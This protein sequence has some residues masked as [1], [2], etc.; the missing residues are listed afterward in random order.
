MNRYRCALIRAAVVL[1]L[2]CAWCQT[3]LAQQPELQVDPILLKQVSTV[4]EIVARPDNKLWPGWNA[5][6]TP[7]LIYL[8][9]QQELLLNHPNPPAG[10]VKYTGRFSAE[11]QEVFLRDGETLIEWDAQNTSRDVYGTETLVLADTLSNRKQWLRGWAADPRENETKLQDTDYASLRADAYEQIATIAHEAFHVF[12]MRELQHKVA[13]ERMIRAYPCLSVENNVGFA[14]EAEA[15]L[16][17]LRA[18]NDTELRSAAV[19]WLAIRQDR[20]Q[21]L[22]ADAI[23]YE[24]ANE[25][26][27][28]LAKYIEVVCLENL[29]GTRADESLW[30]SQGFAGFDDT[31]WFREKRLEGLRGNLRGEV[32]VNNDPYGSSPVRG[33]LYFSGMGIGLLLDRI[34][35][36]WKSRIADPEMTLTRLVEEALEPSDSE[37]QRAVATSKRTE[38]YATLLDAKRELA[39]QGQ[40]DTQRMLTQILEGPNLLVEIDWSQLDSDRIGLS[41]TAF[42]V[43]GVTPDQTIYTLVPISAQLGSSEYS[44]AQS[45]PILTYEDRLNKTFRFQTAS[46]VKRSDLLGQMQVGDGESW[47][48]EDLSLALPGAQVKAKRASVSYD[49]KKLRIVCLKAS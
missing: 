41:F 27:E 38:E 4:W 12:Q 25:F 40:Q 32:N 14:M 17:A 26:I 3:T 8:P 1:T 22:P 35:P 16:A 37:L 2:A 28:G 10:F 21:N 42:G 29:R 39:E 11:G 15:L 49:G 43:R 45:Q 44:F 13:D 36:D 18:E 7:V 9:G 23:T 20:R 31:S 48:V 6:D 33:R 47:I 30:F 24:D 46:P 5:S 19:R 34:A